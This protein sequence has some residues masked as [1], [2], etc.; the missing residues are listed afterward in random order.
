M[1]RR[2]N[3]SALFKFKFYSSHKTLFC[4]P[5]FEVFICVCWGNVECRLS[6]IIFFNFRYVLLGIPVAWNTAKEETTL[7]KLCPT[8]VVSGRA[9]SAVILVI[10]YHNVSSACGMTSAVTHVLAMPEWLEIYLFGYWYT[11]IQ[12]L[13]F[14]HLQPLYF[15]CCKI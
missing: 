8:A 12:K 5:F 6:K 4:F 7:G 15:W 10:L 9:G 11:A 3:F 13:E 2:D 14:G 1:S